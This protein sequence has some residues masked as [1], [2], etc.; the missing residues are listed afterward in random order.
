MGACGFASMKTPV[1]VWGMGGSE[2]VTITNGRIGSD[3]MGSQPEKT[4]ITEMLRSGP[5]VTATPRPVS[6]CWADAVVA[7]CPA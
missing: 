3:R 2:G 6:V 1:Q 4:N 7:I 5:S